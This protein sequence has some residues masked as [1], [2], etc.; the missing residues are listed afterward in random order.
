MDF[1]LRIDSGL[2]TLLQNVIDLRIRITDKAFF[3]S[4]LFLHC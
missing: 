4:F 1:V 2:V 3:V